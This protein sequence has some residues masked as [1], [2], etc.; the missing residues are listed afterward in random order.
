VQTIDQNFISFAAGSDFTAVEEELTFSMDSD[1]S[2]VDVF[3][4][5]DDVLEDPESFFL[6]LTTDDPMVMLNPDRAEVI[7]NDTSRKCVF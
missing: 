1:R 6:D 3:L 5:D 7:V 2:C 4:L